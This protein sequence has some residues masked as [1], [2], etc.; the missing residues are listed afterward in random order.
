[1]KLN[2]KF[3]QDMADHYNISIDELDFLYKVNNPLLLDFDC[4]NISEK[5]NE[6]VKDEKEKVILNLKYAYDES[7]KNPW[8]FFSRMLLIY[9]FEHMNCHFQYNEFI[10]IFYKMY[11]ENMNG[12]L[13][14]CRQTGKT[15]A[16][17]GLMYYEAFINKNFDLLYYTINKDM[18][19][20]FFHNHLKKLIDVNEPFMKYIDGYETIK[21]QVLNIINHGADIKAEEVT[22]EG[23]GFRFPSHGTVIVDDIEFYIEGP[24]I[25]TS[26]IASKIKEFMIK[27]VPSGLKF[28]GLG[29]I[30]KHISNVN[31][32]LIDKAFIQIEREDAHMF[33][34]DE[35]LKF[36]KDLSENRLIRVKLTGKDLMITRDNEAGFAASVGH[37]QEIMEQEYY[38]KR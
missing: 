28:F 16:I 6:C 23:R 18:T 8:F 36:L 13:N 1:M 11:F 20:N 38:L 22:R 7:A 35:G 15:I 24:G 31:R 37:G 25:K 32:F 5:L 17:S 12:V 19:N 29:T 21:R 10:V 33:F 14:S 26:F 4:Y 30:N 9:D 34:Y 27:G 2:I 3:I